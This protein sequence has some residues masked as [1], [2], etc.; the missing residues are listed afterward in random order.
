MRHTSTTTNSDGSTSESTYYTQHWGAQPICNFTW[1]I[2]EFPDLNS[3]TGMYSY[4]FLI[5]VPNW[6]P[7]SMVMGENS[8]HYRDLNLKIEYFLKAKFT[9]P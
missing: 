6:L 3:P 1:I 8:F 7:G 4:P 5:E 2:K 9:Q